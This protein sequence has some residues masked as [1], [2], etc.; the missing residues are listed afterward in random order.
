MAPRRVAEWQQVELTYRFGSAVYHIRVENLEKV[1]K[2][3]T[4]V[5]LDGAEQSEQRISLQ[6]DGGSHEVA[7]V[8]GGRKP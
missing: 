2:G 4:R 7:V 1:S 3:V 8:M 5:S 6:D